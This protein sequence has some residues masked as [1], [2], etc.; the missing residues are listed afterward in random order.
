MGYT[1]ETTKELKKELRLLRDDI[2]G[3]DYGS[4][5]NLLECI[6]AKDWEIYEENKTLN[7]R[8]AAIAIKFYEHML[9]H[10]EV[11]EAPTHKGIPMCKICEKDAEEIFKSKV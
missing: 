3:L 1:K 4:R 8:E 11:Q 5:G 6:E 9:N 7:D 10:K 2:Y